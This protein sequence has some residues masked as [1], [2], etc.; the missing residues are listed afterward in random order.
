MLFF[1]VLE[2]HDA[3]MAAGMDGRQDWIERKICNFLTNKKEKCDNIVS[4]QCFTVN[5][6]ILFE[7]AVLEVYADHMESYADNWNSEKCPAF[8]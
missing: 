1:R 2:S 3:E 7:D 8:T 4:R 5:E 6:K